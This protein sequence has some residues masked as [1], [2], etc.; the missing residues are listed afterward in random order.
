MPEYLNRLLHF[1]YCFPP[2]SVLSKTLATRIISIYISTKVLNSDF[3]RQMME[4]MI[5]DT[6]LNLWKLS[7]NLLLILKQEDSPVLQ[8]ATKQMNWDKSYPTPKT[9]HPLKLRLL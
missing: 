7:G 2:G 1:S 9:D 5:Q 4:D 8:I 3:A 6:A